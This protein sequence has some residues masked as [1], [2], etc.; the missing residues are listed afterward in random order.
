ML[1]NQYRHCKPIL[2]MGSAEAMLEKAGIPARLSSGKPDPGL[3]Q[4]R[5][6]QLR[7]ALAAFGEALAR[8]RHFERETD[9]PR[10]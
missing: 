4:C 2:L 10:V 3:L 6:D 5:D 1:I 8:R 7:P 9:P